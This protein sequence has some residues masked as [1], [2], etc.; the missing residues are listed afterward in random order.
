MAP[1]KC[2]RIL[3]E[4]RRKHEWVY[5]DIAMGSIKKVDV[6]L[7]WHKT[8]GWMYLLPNILYFYYKL[9]KVLS[10]SLW[11]RDEKKYPVTVIMQA[12]LLWT[13]L[14][15]FVFA[16]YVVFKAG[17]NRQ[18]A[19]SWKGQQT[20]DFFCHILS[21]HWSCRFIQEIFKIISHAFLSALQDQIINYARHSVM[22]RWMCSAT[23]IAILK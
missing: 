18:A 8:F 14:K 13:L 3:W 7:C 23:F 17:R 16:C 4:E 9:W 22:F 19:K 1:L 5:K 10:S 15:I 6:L 12:R 11:P 21:V 2:L 20:T